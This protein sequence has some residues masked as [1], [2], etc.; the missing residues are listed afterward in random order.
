MLAHQLH[1]LALVSGIPEPRRSE[2]MLVMLQAMIDES[3][4]HG[5][6]PRLFVMG[7]YIASVRQW[8]KLTDEWRAELLRDP[9]IRS[10]SFR[11]AF[12]A[13][14]RPN[15][16]FHRMSVEERDIRVSNLR[17][18]IARNTAAQIGIGFEVSAHEAAY[19]WDSRQK[20][21]PYGYAFVKLLASMSVLMQAL[22][23]GKQRVDFIFDDQKK[24]EKAIIDGWHHARE[25][26]RP[27]DPS[28]FKKVLV[29]TPVFRSSKEVIA[30]QAA[31]FFVGS[32]RTWNIAVINGRDPHKLWGL[33]DSVPRAFIAPTAEQIR[34]DAENERARA[35]T[36]RRGRL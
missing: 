9:R 18:I 22:K 30:L 29:N 36:S 3:D 31:D 34:A 14:G 21:N 5:V 20:N 10:F 26:T 24:K 4:S 15:A 2:K 13:G 28:N 25:Y 12:P 16:Q 32:A 1:L 23:L 6:T 33:V 7:G 27:D 17:E 11:E 35:A 19:S 8:Q